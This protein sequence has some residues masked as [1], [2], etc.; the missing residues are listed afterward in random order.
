MNLNDLLYL[1]DKH[2]RYKIITYP[3][4]AKF[5]IG[6]YNNVVKKIKYLYPLNKVISNADINNLPIT[7]HMKNKL[8]K[9]KKQK[10]SDVDIKK[11][12]HVKLVNELIDVAGIGRY[13]AKMLIKSGLTKLADLKLKKYKTQLTDSTIMLMK[14]K[15]TIRIPYGDIKKIEKKLTSFPKSIIVGGFIRKK[16]CSKDIDIMIVSNKKSILDEYEKYLSMKFRD[17]RVYI[18]GVDKISLIIL[19]REKTYY[20]VDVFRSDI[21][22]QH[23]MLLYSTGSKEFNIKMRGVASRMGYLLN[24]RGLYKKN[25][26]KPLVIHSERSIFKKLNMMYVKPENR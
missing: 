3:D 12:K 23:A 13:K 19:I 11:I 25:S 10:I 14:Y 18:R 26:T 5:I 6:S 2:L 15:P 16:P 8:L 17:V 1:F 22:N 9:L 4:K 24:Q 21:A 20:K 7:D